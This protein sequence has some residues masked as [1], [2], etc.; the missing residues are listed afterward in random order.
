MF[1]IDEKDSVYGTHSLGQ[2]LKELD[3]FLRDQPRN[4]TDLEALLEDTPT[5]K[6]ALSSLQSHLGEIAPLGGVVTMANSKSAKSPLGKSMESA[7]EFEKANRLEKENKDLRAKLK[8][9]DAV[10]ISQSKTAIPLVDV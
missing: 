8:K 10:I 7:K 5:A 1:L 9:Q 6:K 4:G 2:I 3:S